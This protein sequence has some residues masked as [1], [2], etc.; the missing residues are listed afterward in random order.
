MWRTIVSGVIAVCL[1]ASAAPA[2]AAKVVNAEKWVV[3]FCESLTGFTEGFGTIRDQIIGESDSVAAAYAEGDI[4]AAAQALARMAGYLDDAADIS[5]DTAD[6]FRKLPRPD[7]EGGRALKRSIG[8]ILGNGLEDIAGE[9]ATSAD[10]IRGLRREPD[11]QVVGAGLLALGEHLIAVGEEVGER[12]SKALSAL[13]INKAAELELV[14]ACSEAPECLPL[15]G[16]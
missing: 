14:T 4:N 16:P 2:G 5:D 6:E 7:V 11:R 1:L 12:I 9:F 10:D 15:F 13:R 3:R 8:R